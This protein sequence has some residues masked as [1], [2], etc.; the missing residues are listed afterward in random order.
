MVGS[1]NNTADQWWAVSVTA[2]LLIPCCNVDTSDIADKVMKIFE[3]TDWWQC[4]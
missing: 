4:H 3:K 1:V 2:V